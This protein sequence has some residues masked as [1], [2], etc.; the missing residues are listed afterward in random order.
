MILGSASMNDDTLI[1]KWCYNNHEINSDPGDSSYGG[2]DTDGGLYTWAEAMYLPSACNSNY[3]NVGND[4]CDPTAYVTGS[5]A[6]AKRQGLCPKGWHIPSD[7]ETSVLENYL[8]SSISLSANPD[9]Y[10]D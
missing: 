7:Y 8:D 2:C 6:S 1:E 9:Y 3:S 4:Y 10:A 5:N